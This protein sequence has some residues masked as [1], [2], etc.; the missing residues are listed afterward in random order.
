MKKLSL[1]LLCIIFAVI[2]FAQTALRDSVHVKTAIFEAM[3][4]ETLEEPLWVK[5]T[6]L[7]PAGTTSRAGMD[8][9]VVDFVKTSDNNDYV[10]NVYDKGHMAP[11][12]DFNCTKEM[13]Y[14]TFSFVNCA[15]QNQYLN[16]GVWRILEMQ[17]REW[18]KTETVQVTI[19][20]EF[21]D[22]IK[23]PT[24]ATVP[25][26]FY[27]TIYLVDSKKTYKYYFPNTTPDKKSYSEYLIN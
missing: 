13:L 22:S 18:A 1:L 17:E 2:A 27:K 16:R 12:A 19:H 26:G 7:C 20:L 14:M 11:A 8:F 10:N 15:L 6:V 21:K 4:S 25:S 3:Y 9:Y 5:Y 24:G 23:L